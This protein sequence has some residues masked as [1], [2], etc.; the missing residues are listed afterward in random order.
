MHS[1]TKYLGGHSDVLL[2]IVT[3]SPYTDRGN[4]LAPIMKQ[5][6]FMVGGV[7]SPMDSWL[8]L[9]G[10]R[11]LHVRVERQCDT[12]LVIAKHLYQETHHRHQNNKCDVDSIIV[13]AVHY[14]GLQSHPRHKVAQR[15]MKNENYGG[16]L[17]VELKSEPL[18]MAFAGGTSWLSSCL[19]VCLCHVCLR[20][21]VCGMFICSLVIYICIFLPLII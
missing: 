12:A 6:Q 10:M 13:T 20:F 1:G 21:V 11:T 2:G 4:E 16:V 17:S 8:T 9:R 19:F 7:A 5:T 18:A 3:A 15:Q 14:P